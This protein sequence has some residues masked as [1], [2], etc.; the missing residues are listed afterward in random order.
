MWVSILV[1]LYRTFIPFTIF[2]W[3]LGGA[4]LS[5]LADASD[6]MLF[7][8]FGYGYFDYFGPNGYHF[9]D[10]FFDTYYLFFEFL[11]A[12][13]W[14]N[15]LARRTAAGLFILRFS[16]AVLFEL[17]KIRWLFVFAP[18][19]FENF[20]LF[21]TIAKKWTRFETTSAKKLTIV[22]LVVGIP[23]II[24]EYLMHFVYVDRTWNFL[25]NTFFWWL[26][27]S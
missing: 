19:I 20:Y 15:A 5:M 17:T 16:G 12:L 1:I 25:R 2:R 7:Q 3:P 18:N 23:K 11:V 27:G 13:K 10:K 22:L 26:Y 4:I 9:F 21:Y 8:Q 14:T 24:Q 6:V